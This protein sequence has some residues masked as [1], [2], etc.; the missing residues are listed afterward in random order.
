MPIIHILPIVPKLNKSLHRTIISDNECSTEESESES[1]DEAVVG[2]TSDEDKLDNH[3]VARR[4]VSGTNLTLAEF[5]FE[6]DGIYIDEP[7][8]ADMIDTDEPPPQQSHLTPHEQLASQCLDS[9]GY[10]PDG[11]SF[12]AQS[13]DSPIHV[14]SISISADSGNAIQPLASPET[15]TLANNMSHTV[16]ESGLGHRSRKRKLDFTELS[17]CLCDCQVSEAERKKEKAVQCKRKGCETVWYHMEC[18]GL[19]QFIKSWTCDACK[20]V[21]R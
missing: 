11:D 6:Q 8:D 15:A 13:S 14:K 20:S 12:G 21:K 3:S 2:G 17:K 7:M 5:E 9:S 18:V 10:E 19:N 4:L 16:L 1:D